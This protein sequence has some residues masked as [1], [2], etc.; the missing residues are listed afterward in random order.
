MWQSKKFIVAVVLAVLA[1]VGSTSAAVLAAS[2]GDDSQPK[3]L[4]ARVAEIMEV[5][6]QKLEDA[7]TQARTEMQ[8]E[9]LDSYLK[10]LV[11]QG[12][13]TQEEADQ[14]KAWW[15]SKP[16]MSLWQQQMQEWLQ[17][18]PDIAVPGPMWRSGG[19]GFYGGMNWGGGR[20]F[21]KW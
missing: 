5:D 10:D 11:D 17:T 7:F 19:P 9:A 2:N 21:Q 12:K 4:L 15:Q 14:Y 18:R 20:F 16:D 8:N 6:E 1:V 13:I 3:T